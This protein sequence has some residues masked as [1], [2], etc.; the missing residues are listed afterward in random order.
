MEINLDETYELY[1]QYKGFTLSNVFIHPICSI[2]LTKDECIR[3]IEFPPHS[4]SINHPINDAANKLFIR[5]WNQVVGYRID[6]VF[7]IEKQNLGITLYRAV[8]VVFKTDNDT[9]VAQ[10]NEDGML[11]I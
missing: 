5:L 4:D 6:S 11:T 7:K 2:E 8:R 1:E 9:K 3:T 10:F